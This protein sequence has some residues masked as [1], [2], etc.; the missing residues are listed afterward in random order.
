MYLFNLKKYKELLGYMESKNNY[1]I[2][3]SIGALGKYQFMS[4]TLNSL[5]ALYNLPA[6]KN[7][8]YFLSRPDLQETYLDYLVKDTLAYI[9][10]NDL[11]KYIGQQVTGTKR[12]KTLTAPLNIYG[13]LA[14]A[15]LS[16]VNNLKSFLIFGANPDDGFTS[17]SDYA[18]LFS[19]KLSGLSNNVPLLLAFIPALVLYYVK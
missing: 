17:L 8:N 5:Q 6:W 14:A 18:A 15:H 13:M 7:A 16:G 3:N 2:S 19:S 11:E 4:E 12:F 9:K 1:T 10:N